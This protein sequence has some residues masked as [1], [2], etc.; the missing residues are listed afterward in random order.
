MNAHRGAKRR[1]H[2]H[3]SGPIEQIMSLQETV[4]LPTLL[5]MMRCRVTTMR[6]SQ[7]S[8]SWSSD[9]WTLQE[10]KCS[11]GKVMCTVF[12]DR[13]GVIL[14]DFLEPGKTVNSDCSIVMLTKLKA[15]IS[16]VS[17]G[18]M[19]FLLQHSNTRLCIN[20]KTV[21]HTANL[22]WTVLPHLPYSLELVS[23]DFHLSGLK[24][25]GLLG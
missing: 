2:A 19:I 4:S 1:Y 24:K 20:L 9:I 11:M 15:W 16:R 5:M 6:W 7:N 8:A 14:R 25:D 12:W 17:P 23:S 10:R 18:K 3:T 13:K 21:E 22:G